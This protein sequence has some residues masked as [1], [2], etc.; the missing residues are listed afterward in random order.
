[1]PEW[2]VVADDLTGANDTGVCFAR[3]GL[4]TV[5]MLDAGHSSTEG[6]AL[7]EAQAWVLSTESRSLPA[8]DA[9]VAVERSIRLIKGWI[10]AGDEPRIYKKVDSA[11]RGNPAAE[12]GAVL[13]ATGLRRALATPALPAQERVTR[14]GKVFWHEKPLRE[15]EFGVQIATDDL[16][17]LFT[18]LEPAYQLR[19]LGLDAVRGSA[20]RLEQALGEGESAVWL[21]DAETDPDL[22]AL[23]RSALSAGIRAFCGSAGLA[24]ALART[25][26]ITESRKLGQSEPAIP[27]PAGPV[28]VVV[29][30]RSPQA[31]RQ[32]DFACQAGALRLEPPLDF[33]CSGENEGLS[34]WLEVL[35]PSIRDAVIVTSAGMVEIAPGG[36]LLAARLAEAAMGAARRVHPRG[37]VLTGG[38]TAGAVFS[39]LGCRLVELLDEVEPGMACGR[40]A[41]GE[42]PGMPVITRAGSFGQTDSLRKA[43]LFLEGKE[44]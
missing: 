3:R 40:L 13:A 30:T 2:I 27:S 35:S 6:E 36:A 28:L 14:G 15:T 29:G 33:L 17:E 19:R 11:L 9:R 26:Q 18:S 22:D 16:F 1:L 37:M 42:F 12:L 23:A 32:V 24:N 21:A 4:R 34:T 7:R 31:L 39:A 5:A 41:G 25:I 8:E 20:A 44:T 10:P 38:D 43:I